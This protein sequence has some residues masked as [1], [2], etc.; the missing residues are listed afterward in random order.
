MA[1]YTVECSNKYRLVAL[2][3]RRRQNKLCVHFAKD[4]G[5]AHGRPY[6]GHGYIIALI[7]SNLVST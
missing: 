6:S 7:G 2:H 4:P 3:D 5:P 1:A